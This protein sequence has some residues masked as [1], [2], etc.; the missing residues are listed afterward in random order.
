MNKKVVIFDFDGTIADSLG[1][2]IAIT[3]SLSEKY[4]FPPISETDLQELKNLSM[5]EI[6]EK[7]KLPKWKLF[8]MFWSGKRK[9]KEVVNR[10]KPF[11]EC[12]PLIQ[13]LKEQGF[14]LGIITFN[15][16]FSVKS[17]LEKNGLDDFNFIVSANAILGKAMAIK[18]TIRKYNFQSGDV[19]YVGDEIRDIVAAKKCGV[20]CISVTWGYNSRESLASNNPTCLVDKP[21]EILNVVSRV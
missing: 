15:S 10:V 8:L 14:E 12:V 7:W 5:F 9:F 17:F 19:V 13:K 6:A 20:D 16:V 18:K 21:E 4:S 11:P 3:N 2:V 1:E